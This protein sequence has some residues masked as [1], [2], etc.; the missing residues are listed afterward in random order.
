[1]ALEFLGKDPNSPNGGSPTFWR[2]TETGDIIAQG[3]TAIAPG[4][5]A[6]IGEVPEGEALIRFPQRMIPFLSVVPE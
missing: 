2:D 4:T 5:L 6:E 1:M 3:Y